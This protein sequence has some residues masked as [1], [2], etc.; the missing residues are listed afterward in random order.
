MSNQTMTDP[1]TLLDFALDCAWQAGRVTLGYF[2]N[3]VAVERKADNSPVTAADK[4]AEQRIR[5]LIAQYWPDDGIIGEEFGEQPGSSG[6]TWIIDPIDGTKSFVHG[7]PLYSNLVAVT[8]GQ[9]TVAGVAH[10]PALNE[11]IYAARGLG[12]YWNGRRTQVSATDKMEDAA[13][14]TSGFDGFNTPHKANA[15]KQIVDSTYLQRTWGDSYGYALVSTGRADLMVEPWLAIW[16][17]APFQ[18]IME[19][20][21]G[22]FTTWAGERRIDAGNAIATNGTLFETVMGITRERQG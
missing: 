22:T 16:D 17:A 9:G 2:Q 10:Y 12:C 7:V 8:D 4:G 13:V 21:G 20:A 5:Q 19:E 6:M 11:T 3:G 14:M 15:W 1:Q 18:V